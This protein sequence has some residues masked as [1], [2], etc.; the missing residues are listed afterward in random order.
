MPGLNYLELK[1]NENSSKNNIKLFTNLR[2]NALP[3]QRAKRVN[4]AAVLP[5]CP[6]SQF[7]NGIFAI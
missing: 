6:V 1:I 5:A 7:L 4:P 3:D 2:I